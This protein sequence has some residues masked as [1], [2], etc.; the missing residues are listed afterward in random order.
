MAPGHPS[1]CAPRTPPSRGLQACNRRRRPRLPPQ[2]R[3]HA[4]GRPERGQPQPLAGARPRR[5]RDE[6]R[7]GAW[8]RDGR[9]QD[10]VPVSVWPRLFGAVGEG[11][12]AVGRAGRRRRRRRAT[13]RSGFG[14]QQQPPSLVTPS[15]SVGDSAAAAIV[16]LCRARAP[17]AAMRSRASA[18]SRRNGRRAW[19][20]SIRSPRRASRCFRWGCVSSGGALFGAGVCA[21]EGGG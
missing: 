13:P 3:R 12:R 10:D 4:N 2:R 15:G 5:R 16:I 1:R 14:R 17:M 19:P 6:Q 7:G 21:H 9:P 20:S 11:A 18:S 8:R